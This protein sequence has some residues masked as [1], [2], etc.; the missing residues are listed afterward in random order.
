M[1]I[2]STIKIQSHVQKYTIPNQTSLYTIH[3]KE[4]V[5]SHEFWI[6]MFRITHPQL[7]LPKLDNLFQ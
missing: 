4:P 2:F 7:A 5:C 6:F 3:Q 1:A